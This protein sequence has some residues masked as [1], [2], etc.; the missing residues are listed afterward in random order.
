MKYI[1]G[2]VAVVVALLL[3]IFALV[4]RPSTPNNGG[5]PAAT[6]RDYATR[7]G[8]ASYTIQGKVVG[9]NER[10]AVRISVSPEQRT[11]EILQGYDETVESREVFPN[12]E[13]AYNHFIHALDRAGFGLERSAEAGDER[14]VCPLGNTYIYH[15]VSNSDE[16]VS[17][18][19]TTCSRNQGTFAGNARLVRQLFQNQ[20]PEYSRQ[21]RDVR[22]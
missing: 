12:T 5:Q 4:R 19:S 3:I 20:I 8:T 21:I 18:W 13:S 7:P 16:I 17:T 14:G 2:V 11:I 1:I 22:L 15:L 10:Q 6:V 9:E